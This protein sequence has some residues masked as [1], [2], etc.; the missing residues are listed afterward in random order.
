MKKEENMSRNNLNRSMETVLN[1][2]PLAH[3]TFTRSESP[4]ELSVFQP[5][6]EYSPKQSVRPVEI[7]YPVAYKLPKESDAESVIS[8]VRY[9][10]SGQKQRLSQRSSMGS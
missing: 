5:P 7:A 10:G 9:T 4:R 8:P 6:V 3:M 2:Q 1:R